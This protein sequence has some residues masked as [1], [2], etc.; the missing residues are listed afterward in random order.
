MSETNGT[1]ERIHFVEVE[2]QNHMRVRRAHVFLPGRGVVPL[3]GG[4]RQGKTSFKRSLAAL[5]GGDSV[6]EDAPRNRDAPEDEEAYIVGTLSNGTTLR[7]AFTGA[8]SAPKGRLTAKD[9]EDRQLSQAHLNAIVG[10]RAIEP[11]TFFDRRANEQAE[12]LMGFAPGLKE[13]L[14]ELNVERARLEEER[15]PH[16]SQLQVLGRIARPEGE[17]PEPIDVSEAMEE[18]R[19]LQGEQRRQQDQRSALTRKQDEIEANER[20][21]RQASDEVT[22]LQEQLDAAVARLQRLADVGTE[23]AVQQAELEEAY[24]AE[25]SVE[26]EIEAVHERIS[27]ADAVNASLKPWEKWEEA[28]EAIAAHRT[29]RDRL[30]EQLA[31]VERRKTEALASA[32]LPFTALSIDDDGQILIDG[33]PLSAASGMER[34]RLALEVAIADDPDLGVVFMNGNELDDDALAEIHRMAEQ[35]DFQVIMDLIRS[36]DIEGAVTM[37]DGVA[38]QASAEPVEV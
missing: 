22:R 29:E 38:H 12:I 9:A 34:C 1:R 10:P 16:N 24:H 35:F 32:E 33:S 13:T 36:T 17:R 28:Q 11:M 26:P 23:L 4:N 7:R 37:V 3:S 8:A 18:L 30:N 15:R 25:K 27:Q 31:E 20:A 6:V 19:R 5:L 21:Q 2:I 14:D